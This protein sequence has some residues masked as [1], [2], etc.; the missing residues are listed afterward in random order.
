MKRFRVAI[1][2]TGG[3]AGIHAKSLK[4]MDDRVDLVAGAD[5]DPDRLAKFSDQHGIEGRYPDLDSL[6]TEAKPDIVHLC[7]PPGLHREQAIA[8][9]DAG[10]TALCEK[11]PAL[12]V[13]EMD[14]IGDAQAR[15][16]GAYFATVFQH[17][18]GSGATTLRRLV[19]EGAYGQPRVA[20]CNTLWYRPD[21]YFDVPWRGKWAIEGG[22]PTMGHGIHQFD[23]LLSILGDWTEVTAVASR[24]ARPTE[25]E[26]FSSA[27][28][29]FANGA[30]ATIV[31]SLLSPRETSYLRFDFDRAT[32]EVEH[33]YGYDDDNWTVT[34]AKGS[35]D[36]VAASWTPEGRSSGHRAQIELILD[37]L[38]AGQEPPV[39]LRESRRT[40]ELAA[41]IY[42]SAFT[43]RAV[44][45]GDIKAG[46]PFYERMNGTGAPWTEKV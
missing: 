24:L 44:R 7:T 46:N 38:E 13:S 40:L 37:A 16:P 36:A 23:L 17:R 45:S 18:F 41:A 32:V 3:I 10:V 34:P 25:T 4:A 33:L 42:A 12:S 11:P 21:A 5:I 8:C 22:G 43:G 29:T 31:N 6:L 30:V 2:G 20:I 15:N 19:D 26:D 35:E 14:H 28:V 27:I 9:L 1:V 39:S